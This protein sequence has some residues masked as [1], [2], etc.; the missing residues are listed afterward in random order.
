MSAI[1]YRPTNADY[2]HHYAERHSRKFLL[3]EDLKTG[4]MSLTNDIENVVERI[5]QEDQ[6]DLLHH[7]ILYKDSY[8]LWDCWDH[9]RETFHRIAREDLELAFKRYFALFGKA[10]SV[11]KIHYF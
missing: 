10:H 2:I 8:G 3:I 11:F 7:V 5:A 1:P 4:L 6:I 9:Y